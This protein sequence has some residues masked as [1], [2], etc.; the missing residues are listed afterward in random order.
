[1]RKNVNQTIRDSITL[2]L[3]DPRWDLRWKLIHRMHFRAAQ[4]LLDHARIVLSFRIDNTTRQVFGPMRWDLP[5]ITPL[6]Q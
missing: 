6:T 3:D 5:T 1:M 4:P 2:P